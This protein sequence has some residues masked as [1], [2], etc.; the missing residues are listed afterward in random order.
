MK[1]QLHIRISSDELNFNKV[2][3]DFKEPDIY[4]DRKGGFWTSSFI[5][6]YGSEWLHSGKI[7]KPCAHVYNGYLFT[8]KGETKLLEIQNLDDELYFKRYYKSNY[9]KVAQDFDGFHL[10]YEYVKVLRDKSHFFLWTCECT[11]WFNVN[12]LELK[13]V[14]SSEE[15]KQMADKVPMIKSKLR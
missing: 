1:D 12:Q 11:W 2:N 13:R 7:Y 10:E 6:G 15:M 9:N 3:F 5:P 14:F 4:S 8:V